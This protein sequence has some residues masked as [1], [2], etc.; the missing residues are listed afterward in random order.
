M[1]FF[2]YSFPKNK[3]HQKKKKKG[4]PPF[5]ESKEKGDEDAWDDDVPKP[6]HGEIRG[7]QALFEQILG[8][9][10][11]REQNKGISCYWRVATKK[12]KK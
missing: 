9:H 11:C 4:F 1:K 6:Q 5:V 8:E 7:P 10:H 2:K 12:I 3:V